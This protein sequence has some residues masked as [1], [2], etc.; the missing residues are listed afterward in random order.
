[1]PIPPGAAKMRWRH[2]GGARLTVREARLPAILGLVG[3]VLAEA[4]RRAED[5]AEAGAGIGRAEFL[6]RALLLIYLA[7]LDRQRDP[8]GG[9]V[10]RGDLGVDPLT[11][12]KA[13]GALFAAVARQLGF[14]DE[15][16]HVVGQHDLDTALGD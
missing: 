10:D 5:V 15:A 7:R 13:I 3:L 16:G 12:R 14:A 9:A 2:R 4:D 11:D 6:H 8:A 1:M